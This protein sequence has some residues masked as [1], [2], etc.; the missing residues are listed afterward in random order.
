M[1]INVSPTQKYWVFWQYL[2]KDTKKSRKTKVSQDQVITTI[3]YIIDDTVRH[4]DKPKGSLPEYL[5]RVEVEK[6][7]GVPH[8]RATARAYSLN[9]ATNELFGYDIES[10]SIFNQE[11]E[12]SGVRF[13]PKAPR[14]K[15][16]KPQVSYE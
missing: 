13:E 7:P 14:V 2:I 8:C 3:C 11:A 10:Q 6:V 5:V 15:K 4:D 16:G 1:R 9:K 12:K